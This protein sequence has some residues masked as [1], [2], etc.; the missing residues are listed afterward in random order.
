MDMS[1]QESVSYQRL[2]SDEIF[3]GFPCIVQLINSKATG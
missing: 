2:H 3:W 1:L